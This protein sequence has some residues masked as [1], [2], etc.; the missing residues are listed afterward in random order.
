VEIR[1][2]V[3]QT[4]QQCLLQKQKQLAG[5]ADAQRQR[6][7]SA[8]RIGSSRQH[9]SVI[10][11][12]PSGQQQRQRGSQQQVVSTPAAAVGPGRPLSAPAGASPAAFTAQQQIQ[13]RQQ[14]RQPKAYEQQTL[15]LN[16]E[17]A[18]LEERMRQQ[19]HVRATVHMPE[20]VVLLQAFAQV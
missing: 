19:L 14:Q 17:L 20:R 3:L 18:G 13:Q 2:G 16:P 11:Q 9:A 4:V 8:A 15:A 10:Q 12:Q 5:A 1:P 7:A 6:P